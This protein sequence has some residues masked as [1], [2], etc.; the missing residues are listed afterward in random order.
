MKRDNLDISDIVGVTSKSTLRNKH[1]VTRSIMDVSDINEDR[2][3]FKM[4]K[5]IDKY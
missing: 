2:K 1:Y 5:V 3:R 4:N